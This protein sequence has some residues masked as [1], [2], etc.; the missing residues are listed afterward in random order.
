MSIF[1]E[2]VI[3]FRFWPY[4][5]IY[6]YAVNPP[7]PEKNNE[8]ELGEPTPLPNGTKANEDK[9]KSMGGKT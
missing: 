3:N 5:K 2:L 9:E 8:L 7:G 1:Y 6:F 4:L